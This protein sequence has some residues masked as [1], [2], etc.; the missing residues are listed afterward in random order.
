MLLAPLPLVI[1][2]VDDWLRAFRIEDHLPLVTDLYV[3]A[4]AA[5][6]GKVAADRSPQKPDLEAMRLAFIESFRTKYPKKQVTE[7]VSTWADEASLDLAGVR[8]PS[9]VGIAREYAA[10]LEEL[11]DNLL[12]GPSVA[13]AQSLAS[14]IQENL[15][16]P[17]LLD[18]ET[19]IIVE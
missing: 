11:E 1:V 7:A 3:E 4:V 10:L 9:K 14:W 8:K 13:R 16:L 19:K 18:V 15:E 12:K 17:S 5:Y 2:G 6:V